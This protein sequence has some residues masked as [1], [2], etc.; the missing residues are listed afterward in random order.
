MSNEEGIT[1]QIDRI[2]EDYGKHHQ[3]FAGEVTCVHVGT[4]P[5]RSCF[6]PVGPVLGCVWHYAIHLPW[7]VTD[8]R[9][10][11]HAVESRSSPA[12]MSDQD[13]PPSSLVI[14]ASEVPVNRALK[15]S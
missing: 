15:P 3:L 12:G 1:D 4:A 10:E 9:N 6:S 2:N 8:A 11:H 7:T 5:P 13:S 14:I